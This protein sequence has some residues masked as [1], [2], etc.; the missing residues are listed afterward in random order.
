MLWLASLLWALCENEELCLP[1]TIPLLC[2]RTGR[3]RIALMPR[4]GHT[5]TP[6]EEE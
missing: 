1:C 2:F 4:T 6:V 5:P 3:S